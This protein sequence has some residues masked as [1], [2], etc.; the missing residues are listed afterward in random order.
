M[1]S[2]FSYP[3]VTPWTMFR[4]SA[5]VSPWS[6]RFSR[7]S[8]TRLKTMRRADWSTSTV[9]WRGTLCESLPFAPSTRISESTTLTFT[10]AGNSIG[11]F[12]IRDI[13]RAPES[14]SGPAEA[15][16][17][18][19]RCSIH[20]AEILAA[21]LALAAFAIGHDPLRRREDPDTQSIQHLLDVGDPFVD[22]AAR[23]ADALDARDQVLAVRPV[24][25][26]GADER[27][28]HVGHDAHVLQI[29]LAHEDPR[30][31]LLDRRVRDVDGLPS[32]RLGVADPRQQI[33]DRVGHRHGS[34]ARLTS[35]PSSCPGSPRGAQAAEGR[36]GRAGTCGRWRGDGRTCGNDCRPARGTWAAG[37][38]SL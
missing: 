36:V 32:N 15:A 1:S 31:I 19:R 26:V 27:G 9:I 14:Q 35:S 21:D 24:L 29:T 17:G 18:S 23:L 34:V 28:L 38:T 11:F 6:A 16:T 5:R 13:A 30:D 25:E 20:A 37:A 10:V 8:P 22:A 7:S 33:R 3:S 2:R 12:P 4:T